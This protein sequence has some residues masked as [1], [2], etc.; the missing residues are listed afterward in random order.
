VE[1]AERLGPQT[2]LRLRLQTDRGAI[3]VEARVVWVSEPGDAGGVVPHGVTFT[4]LTPDQLPAFHDLLRSRGV[5]RHAGVRLPFEVS[6]TC[7]RKDHAE[8]PIQGWT[9]DISRGGF[10]LRLPH[11]LPLGTALEITLHTQNEPLVVEGA[12]VWVEPPDRRT[13]GEL[14]GHGVRFTALGRSL[15]LSLGLLLAEPL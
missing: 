11:I 12:V 15:S 10:L 7:Q 3:E 2:T 1:L 4:Q 9:G 6:V 8:P 5:V 13:P 14:V